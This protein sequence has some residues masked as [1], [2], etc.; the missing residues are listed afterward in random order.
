MQN[1]TISEGLQGFSK[2]R[3][4][5]LFLLMIL[6]AAM[7][8]VYPLLLASYS[9]FAISISREYRPGELSDEDVVSPAD[10]SYID[11]VAT[12]EEVGK[13]AQSVLPIFS[14]SL[15]SSMR[16]REGIERLGEA[17]ESS[18]YSSL[19]QSGTIDKLSELERSDAM[20][21]FKRGELRI[22]I[23]TDVAARGLDV[24]DIRTGGIRCDSS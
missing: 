11:D 17:V 12:A 22:L 24:S 3:K 8:I 14:Y 18:D 9:G 21:R 6:T 10:F 7:G 1:K 13:A 19:E 4:I 15:S 16:M 2:K 5:V 20:N 23:A